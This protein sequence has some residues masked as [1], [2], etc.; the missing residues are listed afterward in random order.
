M[1]LL[2]ATSEP[3]SSVSSSPRKLSFQKADTDIEDD[4]LDLYDDYGEDRYPEWSLIE[5]D[6][7]DYID[8]TAPYLREQ[9][10]DF[11][12]LPELPKLSLY[13]DTRSDSLTS[14]IDKQIPTQPVLGA[15]KKF[16]ELP[17]VP[18]VLPELELSASSLTPDHFMQCDNVWSLS[19]ISRWC[20]RFSDWISAQT[21]PS[22]DFEKILTKLLLHHRP[23]ASVDVI[24]RN[25]KHVTGRLLDAGV[26]VQRPGAD[27]KGVELTFCASAPPATGVLVE[28]CPCYCVDECAESATCCYSWLCPVNK[29]VAHEKFMSEAV[30]EDVTL[31]SD[32]ASH[33]NLTAQEI[34]A[35]PR[36]LKQQ[37]LLFDLIKF[38]QT[39]LRRANCFIEVAGPEFIK[40]AALV[41]GPHSRGTVRKIEGKLLDAAVQLATIHHYDLLNPL[42]NILL[43][44]ARFIRDVTGMAQRYVAWAKVV[45]KPLLQYMS[46]LPMVEDL[47][48]NDKL[49]GWD[50]SIANNLRLREQQLNGN[51]LLISTFNSR[52]QQ[53][54]LQLLDIRQF[55]DEEDPEYQALTTAVDTI[56]ALGRTVNEMKVHADNVHLLRQ[57][58]GHLA[59]KPSVGQ[60]N[61]KLALP[62][63][64]FY[65]RGDL[66]RKGDLKI[67]SSAVHVI[68]L[69]N[70]LLVTERQHSSKA[71]IFRVTET[72]IPTEYLLFETREGDAPSR[73]ASAFVPAED[74]KSSFPF[75]VRFAGR[76]K[77][78]AH[79][80]VARSD[81]DRKKWLSALLL[82]RHGANRR[83]QH[84]APFSV[85]PV[86]DSFFAYE[87]TLRVVK[88]PLLAANDPLL[89]ATK[90]TCER[91][92]ERAVPADLYAPAI[93]RAQLL[94][95]H[96]TCTESFVF[97]GDMYTFVGLGGGVHCSDGLNVW[98]KV[99][100]AAGVSKLTIVPELSVLLVLAGKELRY[101]SLL[102]VIDVY[103][104]R[105][106]RLLSYVL[107]GGVLFYE[108]GRHREVPTV[109]VA[110][111]KISGTT[112]FKVLALETDGHG[113]LSLFAVVRRFYIQADCCG[114]SIFNTSVAV[115][116]NRG[117]EVLD[118]S[119]LVP[120]TVPEFP[121]GDA[122]VKK[123]DTYSRKQSTR[124]I[125]NIRRALAHTSPMGMFKLANNRE[126]LL[127]YADCAVFVNKHGKLSRKTMLCFN[128]RPKRAAFGHGHLALVCDEAVEIWAISDDTKGQNM[129]VQVLA[130]K[131]VYM[132]NS[133]TFEFRSA[134]A[135]LP[136]LQL[137]FRLIPRA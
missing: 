23:D 121:P 14:F 92:R 84:T 133:G 4:F 97:R 27:Q 5:H 6:E 106:E 119:K 13:H 44:D 135:R 75:K 24:E 112:T 90:R 123:L 74:D 68:L 55:Y 36:G 128:C 22:R 89:I 9:L 99:V 105:K 52:Y 39:F 129:V 37:S 21:V 42:K 57:V 87:P 93:T 134:N 46:V 65:F 53:L 54:P 15:S 78:H 114:L 20:L 100:H 16:G 120:R 31:G 98:K 76:G 35:D 7:T 81:A 67:N 18:L 12:A 66:A 109:F 115:H 101:F 58:E 1:D 108:Y 110:R 113:V 45:Q 95:A 40:M 51:I 62:N 10:F 70:Y 72:P 60:V 19:A 107:T 130:C 48:K 132:T 118:L 64:K 61:L 33:W 30:V 94:Y 8:E 103:Y 131:D 83:M 73:T 116:T 43:A 82:A 71:P 79:T 29:R 137:L 11:F 50:G 126:F 56:K 102:S 124:G 88:L 80:L 85:Q 117:F 49:K 26:V 125:E 3:R 96:I 38:E 25:V 86:D 127:V 63:R 69:D 28:M 59:W 104:E 136:G 111:K 77:N 47:L 122:S 32:W 17:P 41:L 2:P 91:L 34:S